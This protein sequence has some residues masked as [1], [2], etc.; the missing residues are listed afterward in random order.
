MKRFVAVIAAA[1]LLAG[2]SKV[3]SEQ[4]GGGDHSWTQPG[5]LRIAIQSEPLNLNMLL[6]SN[7]TDNAI[8]RFIFDPLISATPDGEP[9]PILVTAVPTLDNGGIS[10]DGLTVT[11]HLRSGVEFSDGVPLTSKDVKFSWQQ[12]MNPNNNVVSR[13]GY[14]EI[15]SID[16][17]DATTVVVHLKER[18]S[19]FVNTFFAEGDNP[20]GI[21]PEHVLAKY[22]NVNQISFNSHPIGSGPFELQTWVRGDHITLVPNPHYFLGAPKLKKIVVRVV[23]DENTAVNLLRTHDIDWMFEPSYAVYPQISHISGIAVR[24]NN[25]NGY[26]SIQLNTSHWPLTDPKFRLALVYA[27]DK[28]NLLDVLTYGQE[29][30][31]SEDLPDWLWAY[32]PNVTTYPFDP[33][34][35]KAILAADGFVAG[36]NG[37][38]QKDGKSVD[39]LIVTNNSNAT[40]RKGVQIL[41]EMLHE[42][43]IPAQIKTYDGALLFAPAGEGGILQKGTFDIGWSGWFAGI[44]PDDSSQFLSKNVPPGGYNYTRLR[45]PQMDAAQK[46]ALENYD[47]PTRKKAYAT[48]EEILARENPQIF[49]WWDRQAQ[50]ISVDFKGFDPNPTTETWNAYQWSI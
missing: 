24:F 48:I 29:K 7:T 11:Y 17:P 38:L 13:H 32:D 37:T 14:D 33:A 25:V 2:C 8:D 35:A 19:P 43:G 46:I 22:P 36:K 50:A 26:E 47:R 15:R 30:M 12:M 9:K 31:A 23:P 10:K 39:L 3:A 49:F 42:V 1:A 5:V 45:S 40:R 20:E 44:D 18:F 21:V 27:I 16:T 28:K 4:T 34:R 6:A 41:Q